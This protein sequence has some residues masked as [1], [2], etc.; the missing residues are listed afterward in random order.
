LDIGSETIRY[1]APHTAS[2]PGIVP[3]LSGISETM[4]WPLHHR[5]CEA[6]R[7]DGVLNDPAAIRIHDAID[8]DFQRHFGRPGGTLAARAAQIDSSL[9]EFLTQHPDGFVVS[10]GEGLETQSTR[11]DN[12]RMRWLTVD[13]PHAIALRERFITPTHRFR[14]FPASALS[15]DWMDNVDPTAGLCIIAQGLLMYLQPHLVEQLFRTLASRF[16]GATIIFDTIP[17]WFSKLT[18]DGLQQTP[19]YRLPPMPWGLDRDEIKTT[20]NHW[21]PTHTCMTFLD[22]RSPRFPHRHTADFIETLPILRQKVPCLLSV[23]L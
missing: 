23:Q 12:G 15:P 20:L 10:L 19:H 18:M 2:R 22:Y 21:H 9:R 13:L 6:R 11:V 14:H 17:R 5:A 4:L 16:P 3:G 1:A 8:Y 7:N